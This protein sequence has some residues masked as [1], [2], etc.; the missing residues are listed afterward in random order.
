[1]KKVRVLIVDDSVYNLHVLELMLNQYPEIQ[2]EIM[3]ALNG[4]QA[5][6]AVVNNNMT[7]PFTHIFMDLHMPV[8]DGEKVYLY[9][10][11]ATRILREL[12]ISGQINLDK[13]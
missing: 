6:E 5:V 8:L 12:H 9:S 2:P 1:M 10:S 7:N 11:K 3:T 13:T 4:Q